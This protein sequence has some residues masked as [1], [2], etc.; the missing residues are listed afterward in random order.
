MILTKLGCVALMSLLI[1]SISMNSTIQPA[2]ASGNTPAAG[3]RS[4]AIYGDSQATDLYRGLRWL[5]AQDPT[6]RVFRRTRGGTGLVR[7]EQYDW[8]TRMRRYLAMD[9]PDIIVVSLGGNDRQD[10]R[11][12]GRVIPA[13]TPTWWRAYEMRLE[14]MMGML[15]KS[16]AK[17]YWLSLPSVRSSRTSADY[18]RLNQ[19]F[20]MLSPRHGIN[21]VDSTADFQTADGRFMSFGADM[22]GRHRRLRHRDGIH[23]SSDGARLLANKVLT[24]I[25]TPA[26]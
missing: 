16:G 3:T 26:R 1:A 15:A 10:I 8:F 25:S 17:V 2:N 5:A 13:L 18:R 19:L 9:Q 20:A 21:F 7:T 12:S 4:V 24:A 11:T 23:Y 22:F 6:L 14:V